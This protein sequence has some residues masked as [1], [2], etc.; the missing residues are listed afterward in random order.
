[1]AGLSLLL[2]E[3][4]MPGI[5]IRKMET[6]FDSASSTTFITLENVKVPTKNLIGEE[7]MG[8]MYIVHNFNHERFVIA[9]SVVRACR[10]C[11][12]EAFKWAMTRKTFG[13]PLMKH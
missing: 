5:K 8:F 9:T 4:N 11:Y 10:L 1:M 12:E 6:Q 13:K 7:G 3:R 2:L